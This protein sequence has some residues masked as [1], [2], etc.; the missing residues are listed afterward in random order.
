MKRKGR[1]E[2]RAIV[3]GILICFFAFLS[4]TLTGCGRER[5]ERNI[6]DPS[7]FDLA[8]DSAISLEGNGL[9][10]MQADISFDGKTLIINIYNNSDDE[11]WFTSSFRN[12][13]QIFDGE[14]WRIVPPH[15][16]LRGFIEYDTLYELC[17]GDDWQG[18]FDLTDY[19]LPESGLFRFSLR[20]GLFAEFTLG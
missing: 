12:S 6:P 11:F 4:L 17:P 9:V 10:T 14:N 7:T 1:L 2:D 13:V 16:D 5:E 18:R 8:P 15:P 19:H 20:N 3:I